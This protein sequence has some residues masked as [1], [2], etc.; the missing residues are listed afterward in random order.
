MLPFL[1]LALLLA[2]LVSLMQLGLSPHLSPLE[3]NARRSA[4]MLALLLSLAALAR[5]R[6]SFWCAAACP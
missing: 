3:G 2:A 6:R 1:L 4:I 5:S